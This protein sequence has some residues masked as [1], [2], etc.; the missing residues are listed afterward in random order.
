MATKGY[1]L[2]ELLAVI[3]IVI[4]AVSISMIAVISPVKWLS[5]NETVF[6]VDLALHQAH[7]NAISRGKPLRITFSPTGL[8]RE[9]SLEAAFKDSSWRWCCA[10][11]EILFLPDGRIQVSDKPLPE[12]LTLYLLYHEKVVASWRLKGYQLQINPKKGGS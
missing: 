7:L 2:A 12:N 8:K 5:G 3:S 11:S 10:L 4:V 6:E 1:T 9:D